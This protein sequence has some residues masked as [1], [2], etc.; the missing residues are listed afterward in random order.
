MRTRW[1]GRSSSV[2]E[3]GDGGRLDYAMLEAESGEGQ[4]GGHDEYK[5]VHTVPVMLAV[6][7]RVIEVTVLLMLGGRG[8]AS[9]WQRGQ[10]NW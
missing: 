6:S 5:D 9:G 3:V 4:E 10:R 1:Q 2:R 7:S 8:Q